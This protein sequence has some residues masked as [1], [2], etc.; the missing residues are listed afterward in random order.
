MADL[1]FNTAQTNGAGFSVWAK[2]LGQRAQFY[3]VAHAGAG[4]VRFHQADFGRGVIQLFKGFFHRQFLA[5]GVRGG[6]AL[7]F[8]VGRGPN[9]ADDGIN[10]VSVFDGVGK[11]F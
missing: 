9:G 2:E 3:G 1:A 10:F 6:N 7:A 4:A 5:L 8:S 11:A